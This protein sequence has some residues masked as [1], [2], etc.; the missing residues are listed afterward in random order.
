MQFSIFLFFLNV[1]TLVQIQSEKVDTDKENV[2]LFVKTV[3]F[4][5]I[6][7]ELGNSDIFV[8]F[9]YKQAERR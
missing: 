9:Y 3:L 6:S 8:F 7:L 5:F 1:N 2:R 4:C